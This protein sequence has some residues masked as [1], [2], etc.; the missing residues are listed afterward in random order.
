MLLAKPHT[1]TYTEL[2]LVTAV[3][4]P[5]NARNIAALAKPHTLTYTELKHVTAV[6]KPATRAPPLC[7]DASSAPQL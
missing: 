3:A 1:L 2:K 6:A 7:R 4:K 5:V